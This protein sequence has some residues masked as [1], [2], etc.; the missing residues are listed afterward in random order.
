MILGFPNIWG[1]L[2]TSLLLLNAMAI[3]N[4]ERILKKYNW[5]VPTFEERKSSGIS[6]LKGQLIFWLYTMRKYGRYLLIIMN[7]IAIVLKIIF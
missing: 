6:F 5:H 1:F 7:T 3:I 4:E 2:E